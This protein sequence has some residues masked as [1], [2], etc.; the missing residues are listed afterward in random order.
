MNNYNNGNNLS[1]IISS[2]LKLKER[3]DILKRVIVNFRKYF[4]KAEIIVMFDKFGVEEME[5]V[6]KCIIHNNGL[7]YSWNYGI[8]IAKN[9]YI[10]QTEDDWIIKNFIN[11]NIINSLV[12]KSYILLK[13]D[14]VECVRLDAAM[15][16]YIGGSDGYPLGYIEK[17]YE[18]INYFIYNIPT[19][20]DVKQNGWLKYYFC[21]HPHLKLKSKLTNFKYKENVRPNIVEYD[22]CKQWRYNKLNCAYINLINNKDKK[23]VQHIGGKFSYSKIKPNDP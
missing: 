22:I 18:D 12:N 7:G 5:N 1:I 19:D 3:F 13:N 23:Y 6:D 10:L 11:I 8:K 20:E 15:F 9:D 14:L 4:P 16:S 17:K 21:N 2:Y